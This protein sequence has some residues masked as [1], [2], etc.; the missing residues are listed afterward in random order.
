MVV[1]CLVCGVVL[2]VCCMV[3]FLSCVCMCDLFLF[4]RPGGGATAALGTALPPR[5]LPGLSIHLSIYWSIHLS[6][7]LSIHLSTYLTSYLPIYPSIFLSI[8]PSIYL[9]I[10]NYLYSSI[11]FG[12]LL[13]DQEAEPPRLSERLSL[14]ARFLTYLSI[15][16]SIHLSIY[17]L[18]YPSIHPSIHPSIYLSIFDILRSG[19]G[20]TAALGTALPPRSLPGLSIHLSIYWSIHLSIYLSIHLSTYLTSYLSTYP[21]IYLSIH[22]SIYLSVSNYLYSSIYDGCLLYDQEAEPP[23]LSE[24][25]SLHAR[26]LVSELMMV[27]HAPPD[28]LSAADQVNK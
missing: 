20:G 24:R 7:Y 4:S 1:T 3:L 25:L 23:R 26:F 10:S 19:S 16:L 6:I 27:L 9:S 21:S 13:Y 15:N 17:L 22:P 14:H 12:C 18:I 28:A 8:H 2:V 11:Y 5:S